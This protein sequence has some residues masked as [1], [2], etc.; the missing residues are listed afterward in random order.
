MQT[1]QPDD[2]SKYILILLNII[3]VIEK[4]GAMEYDIYF[5]G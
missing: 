3:G 2:V 4:G 5:L 1:R